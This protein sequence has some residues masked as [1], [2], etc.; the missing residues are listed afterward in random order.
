MQKQSRKRGGKLAVSVIQ[1]F[2]E[3]TYKN[4]PTEI[5]N[6]KLDK[7]LSTMYTT[8]YWKP[9]TKQGIVDT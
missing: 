1:K 5:D 6:Y 3:S 7:Q 2:I 8:V 9:D 4:P